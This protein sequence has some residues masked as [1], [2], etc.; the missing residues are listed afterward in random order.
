MSRKGTNFLHSRKTENFYKQAKKEGVRARS[1]FKLEQLDKKYNLFHEKQT[2]IDLGCAPGGWIEYLDKKLT[3][4]TIVG[5][6]LLEVKRQYEF[7]KNV[8][9]FQ[10]DFKNIGE[11]KLGKFDIVI[12]DMAPEFSGQAALDKGRCHKLNLLTLEFAKEHLISM[13]NCIM[14]SF[15]GEDLAYVRKIAKEMFVEIKEFKP[16]SSQKRSA[17]MFLVCLGKK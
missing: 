12:S 13:G 16:R 1:Y 8:Q 17:E 6:D 9:I 11:Y 5:V 3:D 14:K 2:I 10:E 15:E 7:S 4:A